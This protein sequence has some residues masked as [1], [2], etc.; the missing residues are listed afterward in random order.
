MVL[1]RFYTQFTDA[2]APRQFDI[3]FDFLEDIACVVVVGDCWNIWL[4]INSFIR[5][6]CAQSLNRILSGCSDM[7]TSFWH[8][9]SN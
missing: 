7:V 9:E 4:Y 2:T 6:N 8:T 5:H 1:V 3:L